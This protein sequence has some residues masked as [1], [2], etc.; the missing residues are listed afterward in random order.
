[1][2]IDKSMSDDE[3]DAAVDKYAELSDP[4]SRIS[5]VN[6]PPTAEELAATENLDTKVNIFWLNA[7][8][9]PE[10]TMF[11][12]FNNRERPT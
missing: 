2:G 9:S 8:V 4:D 7:G 12:E 3:F 1:M 10:D 11:K 6:D 5:N